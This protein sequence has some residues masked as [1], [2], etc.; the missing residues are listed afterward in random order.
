[1]EFALPRGGYATVLLREIIKPAD[2][3]ASGFA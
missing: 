2:P 1:L 3:F